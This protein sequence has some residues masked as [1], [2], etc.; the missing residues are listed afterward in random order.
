M[1]KLNN[2]FTT[3]EK[4]LWCTSVLLIFF[5][6]LLFNP[7]SYLLLATSLIGVTSLILNAKGNLIGQILMVVFSILYALISYT[8]AYYGEMITYLLMTMPMA[9][10]ALI[11]WSKNPY[12][13]KK[14]EVKINKLTKIDIYQMVILAIV[15]TTFFYFVL[16]YLNTANLILSTL[17]VTTSF[18]AVFLSIKRTPFYAIGYVLNDLVLIILWIIAAYSDLMYVS[19]VVC[20]CVFLVND[21]YGFYNWK[22]MLKGQQSN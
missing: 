21:L 5:F 20:F 14:V 8:T 2:Y 3:T 18:I 17:S 22:K 19:V 11:S 7:T 6:F 1:H 9:I 4:I 13:G 12:P 10:F 15:V 16:Q